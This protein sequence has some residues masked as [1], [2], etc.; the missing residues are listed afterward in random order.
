MKHTRIKVFD[1]PS[2]MS[3]PNMEQVINDFIK[4]V[5]VVKMFEIHGKLVIQ[6][7]LTY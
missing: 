3:A 7:I 2:D 5:Y 1:F 4:D 6:Y